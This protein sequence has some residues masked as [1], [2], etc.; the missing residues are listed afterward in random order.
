MAPVFDRNAY[1][2]RTT[3]ERCIDELGARRGPAARYDKTATI[4]L[5]GL[6]L[7][8]LHPV[9]EMTRKKMS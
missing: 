7:G 2:Q 3:V 8:H 4:H 1:E 5:A 9:S 6:H